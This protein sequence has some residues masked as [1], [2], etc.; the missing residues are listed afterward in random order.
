[1]RRNGRPRPKHR[2]RLPPAGRDGQ[3]LGLSKPS[4]DPCRSRKRRN[5]RPRS[6]HRL[7]LPP[8]G[9]MGKPLACRSRPQFLAASESGGMGG[10]ARSTGCNFRP[11]GGMGKP[12]ACRSRPQ[13]LA[14]RE[15]GSRCGIES[16]DGFVAGIERQKTSWAVEDCEP[17]LG[18]GVKAN[19]GP[20]SDPNTSAFLEAS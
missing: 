18:I 6:K 9:G 7:R 10:H 5:G 19:F 12:L 13:F 14:A 4:P 1:M 3:A 15:S 2:L 20:L 16:L 17:A 11:L 8:A